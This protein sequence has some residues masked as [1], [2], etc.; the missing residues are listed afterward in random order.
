MLFLGSAL[1]AEYRFAIEEIQ[2]GNTR[3]IGH[4]ELLLDIVT[5]GESG[6]KN[7]TYS[8]DL[9]AFR[10]GDDNHYSNITFNVTVAD[11]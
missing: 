4:D 10:D 1:A 2:G 5:I 6:I 3:G 8:T 7:S 11:K 9:G